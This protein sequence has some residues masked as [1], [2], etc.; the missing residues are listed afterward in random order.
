MNLI[1]RIVL[2]CSLVLILPALTGCW[3]AAAAGAGAYGGIKA[4]EAGYTL[5]N[6]V[7][8]EAPQKKSDQKEDK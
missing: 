2:L 5:Q 1:K 8:K 4:K 6:P 7:K 3:Y